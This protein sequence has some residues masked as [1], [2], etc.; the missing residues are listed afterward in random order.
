M[1]YCIST[2]NELSD[3]YNGEVNIIDY[4]MDT[5]RIYKDKINVV[6]A[7]I[8]ILFISFFTFLLLVLVKKGLRITST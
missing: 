1:K 6:N 7:N 5:L 4:N 8:L 3:V 2:C